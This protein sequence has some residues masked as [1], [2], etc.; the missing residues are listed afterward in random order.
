MTFGVIGSTIRTK[1]GQ[2]LD[3]CKPEPCQICL[4][5]IAGGLS[6]ICRFGGQCD[7]FYSVAE[8]SF[9]CSIVGAEIGLSIEEQQILLMHDA[10]EAYLG[11]VV[12]PLKILLPEYSRI[13]AAMERCIENRFKLPQPSKIITEIDQ[14]MLIHE[15]RRLFSTDNVEWTGEA[16]VRRLA[17]E[18]Q[19]WSP[20]VA[21]VQFT[22]RA[23]HLGLI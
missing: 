18:L 4:D 16:G 15:K 3:L 9:H 11:D 19:L 20:P 17:I 5:D 23:R 22:R 8:H 6:K 1:S 21:E 14:A 10:S 12:K 2:Y 13:E 7:S